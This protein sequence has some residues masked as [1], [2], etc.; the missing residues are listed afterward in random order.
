MEERRSYPRTVVDWPTIVLT[1]RGVISGE[2]KNISSSGAFVHCL[3]EPENDGPLHVMFRHPFRDKPLLVGAK[4]AWSNISKCNDI[5][6]CGIGI[7]FTNI[8]GGDR[9]LFEGEAQ[10]HLQSKN[11][12]SCMSLKQPLA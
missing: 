8:C 1:Q 5:E 9:S 2:A 12:G 3:S 4:L 11:Q 10:F 7:Q 6:S